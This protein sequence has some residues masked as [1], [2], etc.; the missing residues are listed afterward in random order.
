MGIEDTGL[1]SDERV[2]GTHGPVQETHGI[3]CD[4]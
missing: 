1:E 4:E 3:D 2:S